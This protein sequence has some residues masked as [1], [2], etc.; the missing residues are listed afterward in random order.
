VRRQPGSAVQLDP[1][2]RTLDAPGTKRLKLKYD[3]ML[4][5]FAFKIPTCDFTSRAAT[6]SVRW[7]SCAPR[8]GLGF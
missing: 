1:M 3:E 6:Q 8:Q 2:T 7:S 4:A 5:N